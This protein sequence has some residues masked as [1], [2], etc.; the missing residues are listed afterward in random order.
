MLM[1][2]ILGRTGSGKS[3]L[4]AERVSALIDAELKNKR[5][6]TALR[7]KILIIVPDQYT[8]RTE[9]YY[10][11]RLGEHA[12]TYVG[13]MSFKQLCR[14][15][16]ASYGG[17]ASVPLGD[18]GKNVL[19]AKALEAVAPMLEYFNAQNPKISFYA[20]LARSIT[21]LKAAGIT[22]DE[23]M[24]T[25]DSARSDKLHDI[26]LVYG[27][28]DALLEN[29]VFDPTDS[30]N[31]LAQTVVAD[32]IF[33]GT[34]ILFDNFR[35][36]AWQE[37]RTVCA[38]IDGGADVTVTL[39]ADS[40]AARK[41]SLLD[42]VSE[43]AARLIAA[44]HR[45][46]R[47]FTVTRLG[48]NRRTSREDL[49][50]LEKNL[51]SE[52]QDTFDSTPDSIHLYK[53][54]DISDEV[55][56]VAS[57][58]TA[59][60]RDAGCRPDDF[61]VTAR[62]IDDYSAILDPVFSKYGLP[63]FYHK[64]TPLRQKKPV[65]LIDALFSSVVFG[66]ERETVLALPKTGLTNLSVEDISLFENYVEKW[67]I[68]YGG[69]LHDFTQSVND[70]GKPQ[71]E[72][73]RALLDRINGIRRFVVGIFT[74]FASSVR[75]ERTVREISAA[76]YAVF[77][78]LDMEKTLERVGAEY[79]R[80]GEDALYAEQCR[81]YETVISALDEFVLAAGDDTVDVSRYRELLFSII[82][83]TDIG[84]I[85]TSNDSIIIG[86]AET[87]PFLSPKYIF[88]LGLNDGVFPPAFKDSDLID[89]D[90]KVI[91]ETELEKQIGQT[92][93]DSMMYER[94]LVYN[95]FSAATD[96]VY[97]S[98]DGRASESYAVNELRRI[99]PALETDTAPEGTTHGG[100]MK[101]LQCKGAAFDMYV[102]T[103]D[104]AL[105]EYLLGSEYAKFIRGEALPGGEKLSLRSA[106]RIF[107]RNI[108]LSA[109]KVTKFN[110]CRFSY[111]CQYGMNLR[112]ERPARLDSLNVGNFIHAALETI[113]PQGIDRDDDS[114]RVLVETFTSK[115]FEF[116]DDGKASTARYFRRLTDK[117]F[118]LL[119]IF[120]DDMKDMKFIPKDFEVEIDRDGDV[121]PLKIGFDGG[122]VTFVGKV[123]RVDE[124]DRGDGR[125]Y[126]RVIDYKTGAKTFDIK[127]IFYGIDVQMLLY[128]YA[129]SACD[130]RYK[131]MLPAGVLYLNSDAKLVDVPRDGD[132]ESA[133]EILD[134]QRRRTGMLLDDDDVIAAAG[135]K[136]V[137]TY[138][139]GRI[140]YRN[141][142]TAEQFG[143]LF[144]YISDAL[145]KVAK[146]LGEGKIGKGPLYDS[147][148]DPCRY[149]LMNKYCDSEQA[150]ACAGREMDKKP[151]PK[152]IYDFIDKEKAGENDA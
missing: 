43:Q 115:Y 89:D 67:N 14:L 51:F 4:A 93:R 121:E 40:E 148:Y 39:P 110:E 120:R 91:I 96:G 143:K 98:Y 117:L 101:R 58:I 100:V 88:V 132:E 76:V 146:A 137:P 53:A 75:G 16:S 1:E 77:E 8:M 34:H 90:D 28:Y 49:V 140:E 18:G 145:V 30:L 141:I 135:V 109:S 83:E 3:T 31:I 13:I 32:R 73:D 64:K 48:E 78:K 144:E 87:V 103:G 105:K 15:V 55:D 136:Y 19:T 99:F 50:F 138:K 118:R 94:Y 9:R 22:P 80:F 108:T 37:L 59:M 66:L 128:L 127:H 104:A 57:E 112:E 70:Y 21:Q 72:R 114:L 116:I 36:F 6:G 82:D 54:S 129:L 119:R 47:P 20:M 29:G 69:F 46:G 134:R 61:I 56:F 92:A 24:K 126:I 45:A 102:R 7:D 10:M 63:L 25:A 60:I 5:S 86:G 62:N 95:A 147:Q 68:Q 33:E 139:V 152:T 111:F 26:A 79:R 11:E 81:T 124:F 151:D 23:L 123:D 12:M 41:Y 74:D 52:A 149:C 44:S 125:K 113:M 150:V 65:A 107:G 35:T 142:A 131:G 71:D 2:I 106:E 38:F 122:S 17:T 130:G 85:P 42:S 27:A 97:I 133:Y 84:I